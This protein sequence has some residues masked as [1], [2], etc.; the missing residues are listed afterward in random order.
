MFDRISSILLL[1]RKTIYVP[2]KLRLLGQNTSLLSLKEQLYE[3]IFLDLVQ[4][5]QLTAGP[6]HFLV[7]FKRQDTVLAEEHIREDQVW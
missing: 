4:T 6:G 2:R 5:C 3:V 7:I 1:L